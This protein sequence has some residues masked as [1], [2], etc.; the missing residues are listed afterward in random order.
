MKLDG[1]DYPAARLAVLHQVGL[2]P[3]GAVGFRDGDRKNL[4]FSNLVVVSRSAMTRVVQ[5]QR[6]SSSGIPGV[7]WIPRRRRWR[8]TI[9]NRGQRISREFRTKEDAVAARRALE[10]LLGYRPA[11]AGRATERPSDRARPKA[12]DRTHERKRNLATSAKARKVCGAESVAPVAG[13]S[14]SGA[15]E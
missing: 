4:R 14:W 8:A 1:R 13:P 11:H 10:A 6:N 15:M 3:A 5:V 12:T 9:H 2:L 7:S